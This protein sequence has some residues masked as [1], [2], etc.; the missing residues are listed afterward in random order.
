MRGGRFGATSGRATSLIFQVVV[1]HEVCE[2]HLQCN[3]AIGN[4]FETSAG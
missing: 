4:G 1:V 3:V 2:E